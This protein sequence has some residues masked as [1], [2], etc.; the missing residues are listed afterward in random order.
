MNFEESESYL[1]SL[2]NEVSTMKLGLENIRRLLAALGNP[3]SNY[4][5]V[6]IA[7]TNGK[8]SVCALLEAICLDAGIKMGL[9]T[10]PHLVSITERVRING[11]EIFSDDFALLASRV[12]ETSERLVKQGELETVPTYFEQVTA[13]A[14]L[15]FANAEVEL[16]ILETGLGGRLDA[17]TAAR[18][19]FV[20]ITR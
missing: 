8:G 12:R 4:L 14:L 13:V 11:R 3:Q 6:Q 18:S 2:G 17:T 10:S 16:A 15:A 1:L 5:K 7:G 19:E 20:G 9:T